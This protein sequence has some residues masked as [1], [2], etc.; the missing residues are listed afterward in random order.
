MIMPG[1][2]I[3]RYTLSFSGSDADDH[4]VDLYDI[5]QALIG[6]QRSLALTA[7]LVL[8][9]NIITQAPAMKGARIF[10]KPAEEGSWKMIAVIATVAGTLGTAQHNSFLGHIMY[11]LYDYV[12]SESL[13]VHLDY[14]KSLGQLYEEAKKKDIEIKEIKQHQADSLLEKC[15]SA[16]HEMHRPIYKSQSA[17]EAT[18]VGIFD[19]QTHQLQTSLDYNTFRYIHENQVSECSELF[20]GRITSYNS[21]TFKGRI[22]IS[23]IGHP[24]S[25][26]LSPNARNTKSIRAI[27]TSLRHN[28]LEH[29]DA[30]GSVVIC[31]AYKNTTRNGRLKSLTI[32]SVLPKSV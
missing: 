28:A 22:Y 17:N 30:P 24:V 8:N 7:H 16:I 23:K 4:Q 15:S 5:S 31:N 2:E 1:N 3:L 13:G 9:G 25:F 14:N 18:I 19:R 12:V 29:R 27:T 6:F 32:H 21:N 10:A 26:S 20:E 11:S